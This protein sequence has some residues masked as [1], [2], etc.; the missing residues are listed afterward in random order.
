MRSV[1]IGTDEVTVARTAQ[2]WTIS[3]GGRVG[4]PVDLVTKSLEIRYGPDWK[5]LELTLDATSRGQAL[6]M[7]V[8]VAG[9]T[10]TTHVNNAGQPVDRADTIAADAAL[11]PNP[12]FAAYEAISRRL[13]AVPSGS[14]ISVYQGGSIPVVLRVGNTD[15]ERIQT[16]GSLIEARRTYATMVADNSSEAAIEIWADSSGRLLRVSVPAQ[17]LEFVR[18]DVA[19]VSTR[20]V[21]ISRAGDEQVQLPAN[22]FN[23]AGTLS[24]PAAAGKRTAAVVLVAGSGALDRDETVAGIPVLGQLAGALADRGFIVLRYDKRG[25][26]QSGGRVESAGLPDYADDLAAAV[27]FLANRKDVD[28]KRIAVVGHSDGGSVA[29]LEGARNGRLAA[30][31][32]VGAAG[33]TGSDLILAQQRHVLDRSNLPEV[34]KQARIDLQKKIHQAVITGKGWDGVP[35]DLRRQAENAEFQSMLTFDPAVVMPRVRQPLLIVQGTL[36]TQVEPSNADRLESL[37]RSRKH[38][39]RVDAVKIPG[40]NHLFVPATTGEVA[41]YVSL[42]E[43]QI[44]PSLPTTIADWLRKSLPPVR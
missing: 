28:P 30:L 9:T 13:T 31:V 17:G 2:G 18:D 27:K 24:K 16:V 42:R 44:T 7:H 26:G 6:G 5:P 11:L 43:K 21:V 23:L 12:F 33:V 22:G 3:A 4:P 37:A 19:S 39:A 25:V 29:L 34:D 14:T 15:T 38:Q 8:T 41:E 10:A 20:R 40:V 36:D 1:Q 35:A 32:L